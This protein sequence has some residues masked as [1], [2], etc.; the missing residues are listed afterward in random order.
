MMTCN[1][2]IR[3]MWSEYYTAYCQHRQYYRITA[4]LCLGLVVF[5]GIYGGLLCYKA[6]FSLLYFLPAVLVLVAFSVFY[7]FLTKRIV[8]Q[9]ETAVQP[10]S[11]PEEIVPE[12]PPEAKVQKNI[13]D[14]LPQELCANNT[15]VELTEA[16]KS[17][18][19]RYQVEHTLAPPVTVKQT[20]R[21]LNGMSEVNPQ[22]LEKAG[23]KPG[24]EAYR[25]AVFIIDDYSDM[26]FDDRSVVE[27]IDVAHVIFRTVLLNTAQGRA[28]VS[29]CVLNGNI[30]S[31]YALDNA[32]NAS[33][34]VADIVH[35]TVDLME[36]NYGLNILSVMSWVMTD[37]SEMSAAYKSMM[38]QYRFACSVNHN[39]DFI[40]T[41][42]QMENMDALMN[43][44][45]VKRLQ[46]ITNILLSG[47]YDMIPQMVSSLL[48][49]EVSSL[50]R[51]YSLAKS[52]ISSV[53][54]VLS[55]GVLGFRHESFDS[56]RNAERIRTADSVGDLIEITNEVF[57]QIDRLSRESTSV[58][59]V[60]MACMY[61]RQNL[62]EPLLNVPA[63]CN[64]VQV[65]S[66]HLA[67][68]FRQKLNMTIAGYIN[69]CRV[70]QAREL[71][72]GSRLTVGE[73]ATQVGY[74]CP[75]S[76]SRN[77]AKIEGITPSEYRR[78]H[79]LEK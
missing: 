18:L 43:N 12:N 79:G 39:N 31:I 78:A 29:C 77:F 41:R 25:I 15:H 46:V 72:S 16:I 1:Q 21:I 2:K 57:Y 63:V 23:I 19:Q 49:D 42:N 27:N 33:T 45:F 26:F 65:S 74:S 73:I 75:D 53:G 37:P 3:I 28:Q 10:E 34:V 60:D 35:E 38:E 61:I 76:L 7:V 24:C 20:R 4:G 55:E 51:N 6:G 48:N 32:V 68:L 58:D 54:G 71:L 59:S 67:R 40:A 62:S 30:I 50:K 47:K 44:Q 9:Q 70:K 64:A 17:E 8:N 69:E 14:L 56:K 66:Q 22:I 5:L 36:R 11:Q 52:R 13:L